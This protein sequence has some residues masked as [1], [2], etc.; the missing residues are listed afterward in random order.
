MVDDG[1]LSVDAALAR[2]D[3]EGVVAGLVKGTLFVSLA[4]HLDRGR[5]REEKNH[6]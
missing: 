1:T 4:A 2:V 6:C 3:T 5:W